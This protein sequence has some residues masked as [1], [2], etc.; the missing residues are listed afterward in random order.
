MLPDG[1]RHKLWA[2]AS[3][4]YENPSDQLY[5]S[6][7]LDHIKRAIQSDYGD[8]HLRVLNI[9]CG[10]GRDTISLAKLGHDVLAIDINGE[11]LKR[12][13]EHARKEGVTV[14]FRKMD[15]FSVELSETFD[16][17]LAIETLPGS[18]NE[19]DDL[20]RVASKYLKSR[21][22][23]ALAVNSRYYQIASCLKQGDYSTAEAIVNGSSE[24]TWL[25][26]P[27]FRQ[28]LEA[29]GY[30]VI[31]IAGVGVISGPPVESFGDLP[32]PEK[33]NERQR[34]QLRKIE[35]HLSSLN[36][37]TGCARYMLALAQRKE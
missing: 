15:I 25:H 34:G 24:K 17:V 20:V 6:I 13:R 2:I 29:H 33:L 12:A 37:V 27:E 28:F 23:F 18:L 5:G 16:L 8:Q 36:E 10:H 9:G 1:L 22:L 7:Y 35:E 14:Q 26:P 4:M 31:E 21:G 3:D 11:A 19:I 32:V 30:N